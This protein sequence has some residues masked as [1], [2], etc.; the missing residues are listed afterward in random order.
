MANLLTLDYG[1]VAWLIQRTWPKVDLSFRE[2]LWDWG[3]SRVE[4]V[5][6]N[7]GR[8][9]ILKRSQSPMKDDGRVQKTLRGSGVPLTELHLIWSNCDIVTIAMEDLGPSHHDATLEEGA[10]VAVRDHAANPLVGLPVLG[11]DAICQIQCDIESGI[12]TLVSH[13]RWLDL[14]RIQPTITGLVERASE[15]SRNA[16]AS[17]FGLCHN[18]FNPTSLH[19]GTRKTALVDRGRPFIGSGSMD[20]ADWFWTTEKPDLAALREIIGA[21]V[22]APESKLG[23]A[24]MEPER[25]AYTWHR[26]W[27]VKWFVTR[28]STWQADRSQDG[29]WQRVIERHPV[30]ADQLLTEGTTIKPVGAQRPSRR[31]RR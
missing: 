29:D 30:E 26:L 17:P 31:R 4:R 15:L 10:K 25:W 20:Q 9:I 27:I 24:S 22:A 21:Y 12:K 23:R 18:G 11:G 8:S 28:Q 1:R 16:D 2:V 3:L 19:I 7:D 13:G 6:L 5:R 14:D